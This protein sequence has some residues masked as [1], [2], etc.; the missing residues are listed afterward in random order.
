[1]LHPLLLTNITIS[2][3]DWLFSGQTLVGI[4][5]GRLSH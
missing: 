5:I 4:L 2:F 1:M 3:P